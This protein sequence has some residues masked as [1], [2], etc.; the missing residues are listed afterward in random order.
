MKAALALITKETCQGIKILAV[1]RKNNP[2]KFGLPG[3]KA[4]IGEALY[5]TVIRETAEEV[6]ITIT[7]LTELYSE[8][9]DGMQVAT[10]YIHRYTGTPSPLEG[11]IISWL[12]IPEITGIK[13]MFPDYNMRVVEAFY[14]KRPDINLLIG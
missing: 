1:S 9:Y 2:K 12:S 3:G 10:F 14:Q 6:G 13:S 8:E 4:K 7:N 11:T 5:Q